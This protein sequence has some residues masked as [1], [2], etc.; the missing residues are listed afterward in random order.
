MAEGF[1]PQEAIASAERLLRGPRRI[2]SPNLTGTARSRPRLSIFAS[3]EAF[4]GLIMFLWMQTLCRWIFYFVILPVMLV[5]AFYVAVF[6]ILWYALQP[7]TG[8]LLK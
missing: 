1:S 4:I 8:A 5:A 2:P 6:G 7:G 3:I